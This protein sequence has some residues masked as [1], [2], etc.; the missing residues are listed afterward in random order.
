[1]QICLGKTVVESTDPVSAAPIRQV[2]LPSNAC[3]QSVADVAV[4]DMG[5]DRRRAADPGN[6][7]QD[8]TGTYERLVASRGARA[9]VVECKKAGHTKGLVIIKPADVVVIATVLGLPP[10]LGDRNV[11]ALHAV[12]DFDQPSRLHDDTTASPTTKLVGTA[13]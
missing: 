13:D 3:Q 9:N 11:S 8:V 2:L 10:D 5:N 12:L 6:L 4:G 1:M 7:V